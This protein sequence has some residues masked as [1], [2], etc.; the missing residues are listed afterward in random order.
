MAGVAVPEP[1]GNG[2]EEQIQFPGAARLELDEL[3]EQLVGRARD[4]QQT[5]SRLRGLLSAY[6]EITRAVDLEEVL[7]RIMESAREL[8]DARYAA[9]G[10]TRDGALTRFLHTGMDPRTVEAIG[11]LPEGKGVLGLLVNYPQTLRLADIS[12]H[13]ASVG[14]PDNHPPMRSFLGVPIRA[15]DQIFGN[16]YLS[17]KQHAQQFTRDDEELVTALASIAGTAIE[18][19][20]LFEHLRRRES[21]QEAM[22]TLTTGMLSGDDPQ[23][24]LDALVRHAG[25]IVRAKG[26]A[27]AVPVEG[28]S[29][30]R[31]AVSEGIF[32]RWQD[33]RI[34]LDGSITGAAVAAGDIV[35]VGDPGTDERTKTTGPDAVGIVGQSIAIPLCGEAG[36]SGVLIL[37]RAPGEP[38]FDSLDI[39][40][41]RGTAAHAGLALELSQVRREH[42]ALLVLEDRAKIADDM[43]EHIISSLFGLALEMQVTA[44]K[45]IKQEVREAIQQHVEATDKIIKDVRAVVFRLRPT[46]QPD[47]SKDRTLTVAT[48]GRPT[49]HGSVA[50]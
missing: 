22:V 20:T 19:A 18:N 26:A 24:G 15:G 36:T 10:V 47:E 4:V 37:A 14:F 30:W 11:H 44:S 42:G 40:I 33:N 28:E 27:V 5:Q 13:P 6:R 7:R 39:Q 8:V 43:R 41:I 48:P 21:W 25:D 9:L 2:T 35:I 17:E 45:A 23:A 49:S 34:P 46:T 50:E 12:E 1:G 31:I 32:A 3:L 38:D 16:L 29:H